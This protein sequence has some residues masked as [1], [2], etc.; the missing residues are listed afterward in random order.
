MNAGVS[1]MNVSIKQVSTIFGDLRAASNQLTI[2][3]SALNASL[4]AADASCGAA[5]LAELT[6][7]VSNVTFHLSAFSGIISPA[8]TSLVVATN[9]LSTYSG[10]LREYVLYLL[11]ALP[12]VFV[13]FSLLFSCLRSTFGIKWVMAYGMFVFFLMVILCLPFLVLTSFTAD[14]CVA[15]TINVVKAVPSGYLQQVAS[16]YSTCST[17][18]NNYNSSTFYNSSDFNTYFNGT[19]GN[20][21]STI[22]GTL[23]DNRVLLRFENSTNPLIEFILQ[24]RYNILALNSSLTPMLLSPAVFGVTCPTDINILAMRNETGVMVEKFSSL[25]DLLGCDALQRIF[26][27]DIVEITLCGTLFNSFLAVWMSQFLSSFLIFFVVI[28]LSLI[29]P[30][31]EFNRFASVAPGPKDDDDDNDEDN[32]GAEIGEDQSEVI[33]IIEIEEDEEAKR[34]ATTF[35]WSQSGFDSLL[36]DDMDMRTIQSN[37][38]SVDSN[39]NP[40]TPEDIIH[41]IAINMPGVEDEN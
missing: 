38:G 1:Q 20:F 8:E 30:H 23:S 4:L 41:G 36:D 3:G 15:P 16:Y 22:N 24:A 39:G 32:D 11:W 37:A 27:L 13:V 25:I 40:L 6:P 7:L 9:Y 28:L 17:V 2:Y 35:D 26:W 10:N 18:V 34:E 21:N 29:Y 19:T 5:G 33:Q 14:V 31:I 12:L